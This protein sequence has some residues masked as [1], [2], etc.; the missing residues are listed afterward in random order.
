MVAAR[1][2][3]FHSCLNGKTL[4][5]LARKPEGTE[6]IGPMRGAMLLN[7]S[8]PSLL[9]SVLC[10]PC[11]ECMHAGAAQNVYAQSREQSSA[12]VAETECGSCSSVVGANVTKGRQ[13]LISIDLQRLR[14]G[15]EGQSRQALTCSHILI[16][17]CQPRRFHVGS[18]QSQEKRM[19]QST[20]AALARQHALT[21]LLM[22]GTSGLHKFEQHQKHYLRTWRAF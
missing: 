6:R 17:T 12:V 1:H 7:R 16:L 22:K 4:T 21:A 18:R 19:Q 3:N 11:R 5:W 2:D 14:H 10:P 15:T 20:T 8:S 13:C 9:C